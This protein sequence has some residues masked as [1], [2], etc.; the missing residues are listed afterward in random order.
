MGSGFIAYAIMMTL[1]LLVGEQWIRRIGKSPEFFD[2]WVI[3]LWG[4]VNTFTE[5]HGGDWSVKDMQHTIL[6]VLWWTGDILGIYLSRNNQRNVVPGV[7]IFLTGWG[8]S[9]HAQ[10][11]MLSTKVHGM[12]G[13]TLMLAGVTR[14]LEV[15][16]FAPSFASDA[17]SDNNSEH[18]LADTAGPRTMLTGKAAAARSFRYLP[19]FLLTAAGLLFMSATDEELHFVKDNEM[20]HVTYIL[21]IFSNAFLLYAFIVI[22]I[23]LYT[24]TGRNAGNAKIGPADEGGIELVTP[25]TQPEWYSRLPVQHNANIPA[26]PTTHVVG[27]DEDDED[28]MAPQHRR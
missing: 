5:H 22:L 1:I 14:I 3:T 12:F 8:M 25:T 16:Y 6:G 13:H 10:A 23:N 2:S 15:C 24:T 28:L 7:I 19:P 17:T 9:E 21:I 4:V 26:V 18:T 20:D 11:L 27:E